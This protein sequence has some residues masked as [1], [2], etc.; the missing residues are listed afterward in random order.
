[1]AQGESNK[2]KRLLETKYTINPNRNMD[3]T[4]GTIRDVSNLLLML[5]GIRYQ[6]IY[7]ETTRGAVQ[8]NRYNVDDN[9]MSLYYNDDWI[10]TL[11]YSKGRLD[12]AWRFYPEKLIFARDSTKNFLFVYDHKGEA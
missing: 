3:P 9:A 12:H 8:I 11:P 4:G 6:P 7:V 10:R 2:L 1:M 5:K